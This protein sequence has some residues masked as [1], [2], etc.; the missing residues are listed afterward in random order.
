MVLRVRDLTLEEGQKLRRIVRHGQNAIEVKRAQVIMASA[1]GST[2]PKIAVIAL[3]SED[4]IRQLIHAFNLHGFAMLQPHRLLVHPH[5]PQ[6]ERWL[7]RQAPGHRPLLDPP[8]LVPADPEEL[9]GR[10]GVGLL[11]HLDAPA[12]EE[13]SEPAVGLSPRDSDLELAVARALHAGDPGVKVGLEGATVQV[14]PGPL[15]G[16]VEE[17]ERG[18]TL[19][20]GPFLL[21]RVG[22]PDI[23]PLLLR[24]HLDPFHGPRR[25]DAQPVAIEFG[26]LDPGSPPPGKSA[27]Y[28]RLPPKIPVEPSWLWVRGYSKWWVH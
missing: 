13:G 21:G 26:V 2:P 20:T 10:R 22:S 15:L 12:L 25:D 28:V 24:V 3:M 7:R 6:R 19:R 27:A 9:G 18:A 4:Y 14:A 5:P 11:H 16:V 8:C 17:G 1:Q 23:H